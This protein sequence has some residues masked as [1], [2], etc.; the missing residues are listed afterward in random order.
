VKEHLFERRVG[1]VRLSSLTTVGSWVAALD[2][3]P[4]GLLHQL[5]GCL[6]REFRI[7]AEPN[8]SGATVHL[9]VKVER[10]RSGRSRLDVEA[11]NIGIEYGRSPASWNRDGSD[12]A[13]RKP[14]S[15]RR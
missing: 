10:L 8:S 2:N 1:P 14:L 13:F 6:W 4:D 12:G 5:A 3:F 11:A 15:C 9:A 7:T